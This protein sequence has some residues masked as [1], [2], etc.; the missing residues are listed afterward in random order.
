ME[1]YLPAG[2]FPGENLT[3][4]YLEILRFF[5]LLFPNKFENTLYKITQGKSDNYGNENHN[6]HRKRYIPE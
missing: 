3:I 6:D 2:T 1:G 5:Y 4:I